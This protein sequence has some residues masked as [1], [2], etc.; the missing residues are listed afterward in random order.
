M[1]SDG[2]FMRQSVAKLKE[3]ELWP[4][5]EPRML[6][7][8]TYSGHNPFRLPDNL[9]DPDFDVSGLGLPEKWQTI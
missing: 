5:G 3:G 4:V 6:T 1:L 7:F 2:S 8:V 9:K